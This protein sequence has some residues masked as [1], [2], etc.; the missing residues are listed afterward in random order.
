MELLLA[1]RALPGNKGLHALSLYR[2]VVHELA[3]KKY[4][5]VEG[6]VRQVLGIC[7]DLYPRLEVVY[8]LKQ[9]QLRISDA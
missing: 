1:S 9:R 7:A 6:F 5:E 2:Q 4:L 3:E 8:R